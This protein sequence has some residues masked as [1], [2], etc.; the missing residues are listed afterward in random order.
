MT[1]P[2]TIKSLPVVDSYVFE[3]IRNVDE[4]LCRPHS[5]VTE[6]I[7]PAYDYNIA[8]DQTEFEQLVEQITYHRLALE[9]EDGFYKE[10]YNLSINTIAVPV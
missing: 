6:V 2:K 1:G 7:I 4:L 8:E 5:L 3:N 10:N 9:H